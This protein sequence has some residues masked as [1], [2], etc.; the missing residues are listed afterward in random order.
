MNIV[1]KKRRDKIGQYVGMYKSKYADR[2]H[3]EYDLS[4]QGLETTDN[5]VNKLISFVKIFSIA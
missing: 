5:F 3:R 1:R 4:L 2:T